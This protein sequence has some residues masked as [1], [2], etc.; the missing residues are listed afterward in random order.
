MKKVLSKKT[1]RWLAARYASI[2][3]TLSRVVSV[4]AA[5]QEEMYVLVVVLM[6]H[7]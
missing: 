3:P 7:E 6:F 5:N 1:Y 2:K 4:L